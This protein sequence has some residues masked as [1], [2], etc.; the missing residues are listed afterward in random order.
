MIALKGRSCRIVGSPWPRKQSSRRSGGAGGD[1]EALSDARAE[2]LKRWPDE[3]VP[4]RPTGWLVTTGWRKALDRLRREA[5]GRDKVAQVQ[6]NLP[7]AERRRLGIGEAGD[8]GDVPTRYQHE[9]VRQRAVERMHDPP[10]RVLGHP[11][12]G[13]ASNRSLLRRDRQS[14]CRG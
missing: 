13:N 10:V 6:P 2:A 14:I 7:V 12:T 4:A 11:L 8:R 1:A 5:V 9:P 3:G